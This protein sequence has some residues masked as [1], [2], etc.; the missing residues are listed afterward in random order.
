M[1]LVII[2]YGGDG[3]IPSY[4][5][6]ERKEMK[7]IKSIKVAKS[8][9]EE[10]ANSMATIDPSDLKILI[11]VID[12]RYLDAIE[13]L[14]DLFS[15]V[16]PEEEVK[17]EKPKDKTIEIND[18]IS[19]KVSHWTSI[20]PNARWKRYDGTNDN[21]L[22]KGLMVSSDG[23]VYDLTTNEEI[24]PTWKNG[25]L[26]ITIPKDY[27]EIPKDE[28]SSLRVSV[29]LTKA[30]GVKSPSTYN[31]PIPCV[32]NFKDGDRRN[33]K[34]SNLEWVVKNV[35]NSTTS[36]TNTVHD[37]CRRLVENNYDIAKVVALYDENYVNEEYINSIL[38]KQ[39]EIGISDRYFRLD[40]NGKIVKVTESSDVDASEDY[41][42]G[43][44]P[45]KIIKDKIAKQQFLSE[46]EKRILVS[47]VITNIGIDKKSLKKL[48]AEII[49]DDIRDQYDISI[50]TDVANKVLEEVRGK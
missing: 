15:V 7:N 18:K 32:I 39:I 12:Q 9:I 28:D 44:L 2:N 31:N 42:P 50:S 48:T 24:K 3:N 4:F 30:F 16:I 27:Y 6:E 1:T 26:R 22:L 11:P 33:L 19:A 23:D 38:T 10:L 46:G 13:K 17:E 40:G 47:S 29:I 5:K 43:D 8:T 14:T 49:V 21:H 35:Y 45:L 34:V 37:I 20:N 25:D 36:L 41:L